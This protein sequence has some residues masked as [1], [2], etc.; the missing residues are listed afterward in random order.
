MIPAKLMKELEKEGFSLELPGY[1]TNEK[2]IIEILKENNPRLYLAIPLLL[3]KKI[4]YKKIT[5]ALKKR[6]DGKILTKEFN[7]IIAIAIRIFKEENIDNKHLQK[8]ILENN[9]KEQPQT[10][11]LNYY[12]GAFTEALRSKEKT[13]EEDLEEEIR[14]RGKLNTN[15]ALAEIYA[16]AKRRI[17]KK[18]FNHEK[19][20][21]TELKY[22]YR[23]IRP[24]S[25]AILNDNL[26][27]YLH[28]I[29]NTKKLHG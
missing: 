7:S 11:E 14:L 21:D 28:L 4:D 9:I 20:T 10:S 2:K 1:E 12:H 15:K 24:I 17:M 25:R 27:K 3:R 16:P 23:A 5:S 8:I 26:Q 18:I 22:Y 29:E 19:L 6:K 13:K